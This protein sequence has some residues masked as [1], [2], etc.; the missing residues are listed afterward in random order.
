MIKILNLFAGLGGNRRLWRNVEV[1]AVEMNPD[2]AKVYQDFYPNDKVIVGDAHQYLL[3]N[4]SSFDF[5]WSPP[6]CQSHS[7]IR[8]F[9]GVNGKGFKPIYA[10]M[11]LYQE[12]I[13]LKHNVKCD[14]LVENVNPYYEPLIKPSIALGRHFFWSNLDIPFID[15]KVQN[16]RSRN[17][18]NQVEELHNIDLSKYKIP[19]KRQILRN[20]VEPGIGL[21]ILNCVKKVEGKIIIPALPVAQ[22]KSL[23][24]FE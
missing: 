4:F 18:I 6:P 3:E 12:V 14:W 19:N 10:D 11:S 24:L 15:T 7:R 16:L 5:I 23:P 22:G 17:A 9:V 1:T 2:I 20:C 8:Q 13:F 21:H